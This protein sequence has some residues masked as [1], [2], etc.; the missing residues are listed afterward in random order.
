ME[1][2]KAGLHGVLN[3]KYIGEPRIVERLS[4]ESCQY[5]CIFVSFSNDAP[6]YAIKNNIS[7]ETKNS[8]SI[9]VDTAFRTGNKETRFRSFSVTNGKIDRKSAKVIKISRNNKIRIASDQLLANRITI[10]DYS[11]FNKTQLKLLKN[12]SEKDIC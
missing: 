9:L 1:N 8:G 11:S 10:T 6:Y 4:I 12:R 5:D 7:F 3:Y 2:K